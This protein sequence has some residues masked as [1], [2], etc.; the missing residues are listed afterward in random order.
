VILATFQSPRRIST[1]LQSRFAILTD[2]V[3]GT[4]IPLNVEQLAIQQLVIQQLGIQQLG[5][6]QLVI[7]QLVIQQLGIQ[8]LVIQQLLIQQLLI[9]RPGFKECAV[10]PGSTW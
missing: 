10:A 8:Q 3:R 2:E 1:R 7:Q 5:I 4:G 6:Q 9:Q